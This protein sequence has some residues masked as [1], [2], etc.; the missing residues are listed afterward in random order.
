[1]SL[2][3]RIV[4]G[5]LAV[6]AV[7][8]VAGLLGAAA[9]RRESREAAQDELFRQAEVTA[10]LVEQQ[11]RGV[12]PAVERPAVLRVQR[13]LEEVRRI[14]GHDFIE[15]ALITNRG[16]FVDLVDDPVLL[17][18]IAVGGVDREVKTVTVDG[19]R[20]FA[21][22]RAINLATPGDDASVRMLVAIGR[23]DTFVIGGVITRTL[24][25]ALLVGAALA[26]VLALALSRDLGRRLSSISQTA[27][28][29]A[30]GDFKARAPA[31]G[32][33]EL[34]QVGLA[35]NDMAGE[36]EDL[37]RREREFL[38]S[39]GHDLRTPLTTI[40]G[41][42]EG[43]DSGTL[44][45]D[46]LPDVAAVLHTQ[47][48]RL[49]RLVEDV[50]LLARLQSREFTLEPEDVD[51]AAHLGGV[52][53]EYRARA[54]AERVHFESALTDVG[55]VQVDPD[56]V[57]QIATNLLDNAMRY[58]PAEGTVTFDLD[59]IGKGVRLQVRDTGPG[60]DPE[61]LPH[62]FERLYVAQRYR[63]IRSEAS[64]LGLSIVKELADAMN[65]TAHVTSTPG[66]G[67]T[68]SVTL[69]PRG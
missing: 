34:A 36:L 33:D 54:E 25:F 65:G 62:V 12:G 30:K 20:V 4:W 39:V 3:Q 41:Y 67:T 68:V 66:D 58:T 45:A 27:R 31:D 19:D 15:A 48:D 7:T 16:R 23:F 42:A 40:R 53:D 69:R 8:L 29:Y 13:A 52:V 61:D 32:S 51:L 35:F 2:R 57:A 55:I 44:S 50:M 6:A 63:A 11:L 43:L 37:R 21:T 60:I 64:G 10:R 9:I 14:G 46:D 18:L 56:R 59:T 38:M 28:S 47:T 26:V 49:S 1:M 17:P 5:A 22:V 24:I